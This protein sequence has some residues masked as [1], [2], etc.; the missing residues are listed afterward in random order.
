MSEV[1]LTAVV[2]DDHVLRVDLP[3]DLVG[4]VEL[5]VR[6]KPA[7]RG[8]GAALLAAIQSLPPDRDTTIWR[9]TREDLLRSR[10]EWDED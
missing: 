9:E 7:S 5:T 1:I 10:D 2:G 3:Y 6:K 8:N 4:E